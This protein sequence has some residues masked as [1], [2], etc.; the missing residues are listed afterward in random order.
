MV[1]LTHDERQVI[2]LFQKL[3]PERRRQVMLIMAGAHPDG[4]KQYQQLGEGR[5]R[6]LA[7]ER[8]LHWDQMTDEQ[9]EGFV[10]EILDEDRA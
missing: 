7:A 3:P 8:G 10:S 4:W 5:L 9:R 6:Q 2:S 1:A